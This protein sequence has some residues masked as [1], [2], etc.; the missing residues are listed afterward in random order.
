MLREVMLSLDHLD[1]KLFNFLVP[2][3]DAI[4]V[5]CHQAQIHEVKEVICKEMGRPWPE[6][7]GLAI[8]AEAKVGRRWSEM[9]ELK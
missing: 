9:E 6:L 5:E 3:H 2:I 7:G 8:E 4:L 1:G